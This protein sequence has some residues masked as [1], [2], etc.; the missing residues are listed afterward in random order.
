[1]PPN[2]RRSRPAAPSP[3]AGSAAPSG[4]Q[5]THVSA[6]QKLGGTFGDESCLP[7][8]VHQPLEEIPLKPSLKQLT[9]ELA[10]N[11]RVE[12]LVL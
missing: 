12:A 3:N 1:V 9:P 2:E 8:S 6:I 5:L 11:R 7:R 10:Q 4:L